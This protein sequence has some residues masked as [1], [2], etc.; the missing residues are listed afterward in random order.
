MRKQIA[1]ILLLACTLTLASCVGSGGECS[2]ECHTTCDDAPVT[3][4]FPTPTTPTLTTPLA[5]TPTPTAPSTLFPVT[6]YEGGV[7]AAKPVIYLYPEKE[8]QVSVKL[9]F[10]GRLTSVYPEY[11]DGWNVIAKPDGTLINLES[12]REHYCLFW[13]GDTDTEYDMS[14]GFV[15][16]GEETEAF[17]EDAL[18]KLGLTA[19]EANEFI[20]Y[21]LPKMEGNAYNLVSFQGEQYT[22]DAKLTVFPEPDSI[23][24]VYMTWKALDTFVEVE[25]QML[26]SA[27]RVG[28]TVVE[29]GGSE[30]E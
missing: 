29:W 1:F 11:N 30:I 9:D 20:I 22:Q 25:P 12:G 8:M 27:E 10:N 3:Q 24:R 23:I 28:F 19:R 2:C 14:R 7:T 17:L 16:S 6:T 4:T 5:T 13:E 18:E 15:V 21:W 26:V